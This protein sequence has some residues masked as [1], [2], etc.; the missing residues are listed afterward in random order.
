MDAFFASVEQR[1]NPALKGKALAVGGGSVRGVVAAASYEAREYGVRSAMPGSEA[2]R[3]C[4]HLVFVPPRF[5]AYKQVSAEIRKI[6]SHYT[7]L[8][9]PLS[10]D[11][12]YLDVTINKLSIEYASEIAKRIR[13]DIFKTLGLTASAG[14]SYNKF[15]AKTAS[16][17]NKPNG[18]KV[19]L[20]EQ[21]EVF[22]EQLD[23]GEFFGIGKVTA[24]KMQD[25][26]IFK[27]HDLKA[28]SLVDLQQK[29]GQL[30]L[31]YHQIVRG[32][33]LREVNPNR[34]RKSVGVETT[35]THNVE[36]LK[37]QELEIE[38]LC[39]ELL[40][41]CERAGKYGRTLSVKVRFSD[42]TT[43]TRSH[44]QRFLYKD[45]MQLENVAKRLLGSANPHERVVRLLGVAVSQLGRGD[46]ES[47]VFQQLNLFE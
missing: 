33:D 39:Q 13:S 10:L 38:K 9:E 46:D 41:R 21:A 32:V 37:E 11:E 8:I 29:F 5:D 16:D 24:K 35:F 17:I 28:W 25:L 23:I 31:H 12:A 34:E 15:L 36:S 40:L 42:F 7:D 30:G 26:G 2:K 19:I 3:L 20:P 14:I 6:F 22:L 18:Q 45:V 47:M 1:D 44:T 27:G 43:P 4:P